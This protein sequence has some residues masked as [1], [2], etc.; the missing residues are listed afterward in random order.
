MDELI[1]RG[2]GGFQ[3]R[4]EFIGE[5]V[6]SQILELTYPEHGTQPSHRLRTPPSRA[7]VT[8]R[9]VDFSVT[10]L[11]APT[12]D[13]LSVAEA[14]VL[15]GN[16]FGLHNRDYPSLWAAHFLATRYVG[17]VAVDTFKDDVTSAAWDFGRL[18][19]EL[20]GTSGARLTPIFPTNHDKPQSAIEGFHAFAIGEF[21]SSGN[22]MTVRGPLFG[23]RLC[24]LARRN[25][26]RLIGMTPLGLELLTKL[27]GITAEIPHAE[28]FA[29]RFLEH[30]AEH[31]AEDFWGFE[32]VLELVDQGVTRNEL[33]A[34]I[35]SLREDW[36]ESQRETNASGYI[37]RCREWG[38]VEPQQ[39]KRRYVPT[40]LG[41]KVLAEW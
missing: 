21:L 39:Q 7:A 6:E 30:L 31:A 3:D 5:A 36:T 29:R 18:L 35:G 1:E 38:L 10:A 19:G 9:R 37:S 20:S 41:L 26:A 27:E 15:R 25:G 12:A 23:W 17:P 40:E 22:W 33:V 16:L 28:P 14:E 8:S 24:Q 34:A 32:T 2:V 4:A 13:P 11:G